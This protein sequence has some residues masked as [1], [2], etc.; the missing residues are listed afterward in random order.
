MIKVDQLQ[1]DEDEPLRLQA[2]E[3]LQAIRAERKPRVDADAGSAAVR[4]AERIVEAARGA[5]ARMI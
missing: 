3:F 5:G 2:D 1:I 4:T